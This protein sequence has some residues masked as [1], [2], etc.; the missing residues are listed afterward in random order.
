M[1]MVASVQATQP[2]VDILAAYKRCTR[3]LMQ[4]FAEGLRVPSPGAC[5]PDLRVAPRVWRRHSAY[6]MSL[7]EQRRLEPGPDAGRRN[8]GRR[9]LSSP[10]SAKIHPGYAG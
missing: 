9:G 8:P 5:P 1:E 7:R 3:R 6:L 10:G 4:R 2:G